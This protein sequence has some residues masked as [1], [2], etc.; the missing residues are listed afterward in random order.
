MI[1]DRT[2]CE[3][4]PSNVVSFMPYCSPC[5]VTASP[6]HRTYDHQPLVD[7]GANILRDPRTSDKEAFS[8]SDV[9]GNAELWM[10]MSGRDTG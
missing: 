1:W 9:H 8:R 3:P 4:Y 7:E 2:R 5:S 6:P 10:K